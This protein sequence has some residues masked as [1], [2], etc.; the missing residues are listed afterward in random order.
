L[1]LPGNGRTG[2]IAI[3]ALSG[4]LG[5][6]ALWRSARRAGRGFR[7]AV[8][9]LGL[10]FGIFAAML[11]LVRVP[12]SNVPSDA[13]VWVRGGRYHPGT[14]RW[15][16]MGEAREFRAM[17]Y[18]KATAAGMEPVST[19]AMAIEPLPLGPWLLVRTPLMDRCPLFWKGTTEPAGHLR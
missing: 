12:I 10:G 6:A 2:V 11:L 7:A 4:L 13:T 14:A 3:A 19:E 16:P 1:H 9:V 15:V 17:D 5:A 8:V 18:A